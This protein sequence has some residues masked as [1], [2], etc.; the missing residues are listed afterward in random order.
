MKIKTLT[1]TRTRKKVEMIP[2]NF[3]LKPECIESCCSWIYTKWTKYKIFFC[4]CSLWICRLAIFIR[5]FM[6]QCWKCLHRV[7]YVLM[8]SHKF[9]VCCMH[10]QK[11]RITILYVLSVSMTSIIFMWTMVLFFFIW[12]FST[13]G[14][15]GTIQKKLIF[16]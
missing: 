4:D 5:V 15:H 11:R 3:H 2:G 14:R 1:N 7:G 16:Y 10:I 6:F 9:I 12:I 13:R 8:V